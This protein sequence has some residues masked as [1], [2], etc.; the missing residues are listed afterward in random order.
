MLFLSG[1][2]VCLHPSILTS[3]VLVMARALTCLLFG[4]M[5]LGLH[6]QPADGQP[7]LVSIIRM[8]D[9]WLLSDRDP[10]LH[11]SLSNRALSAGHALTI[12]SAQTTA[13]QLA[14]MICNSNSVA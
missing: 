13:Q 10:T 1:L 3:M 6:L 5:H 14:P 8:S 2:T 4:R 12:A 7:D 9:P 11:V